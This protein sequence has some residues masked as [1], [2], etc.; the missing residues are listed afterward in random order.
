MTSLKLGLKD[1]TT[2]IRWTKEVLFAENIV[3]HETLEP[4]LVSLTLVKLY[5]QNHLGIH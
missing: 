2:V 3:K 1:A 5:F 4:V